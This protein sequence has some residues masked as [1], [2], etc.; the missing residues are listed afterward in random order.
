MEFIHE[1]NRVYVKDER[2]ETIV[3]ATFPNLAGNE[4][5]I[6]HTYVDPILRGKGVASELMEHVYDEIKR[7]GKKTYATCPYAVAW[8]RKHP[9]RA[10]ILLK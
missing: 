1:P 7:Q 9:D 6:D 2:G 10:D 8:F 5:V 3:E 4:V